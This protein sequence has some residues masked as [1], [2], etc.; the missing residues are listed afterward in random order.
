MKEISHNINKELENR[1]DDSTKFIVCNS[2]KTLINQET[3]YPQKFWQKEIM[4]KNFVCS[5]FTRN[6]I[7]REN[8]IHLTRVKELDLIM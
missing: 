6:I 3:P 5:L 4:R 2:Y 1:N 7:V 8:K